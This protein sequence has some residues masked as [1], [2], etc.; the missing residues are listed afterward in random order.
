M[1]LDYFVLVMLVF[2]IV[3]IFYGVIVIY[4]I[5]Y[6]IVKKCNYFY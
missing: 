4:D 3:V 6:E 2:V 5:F 1:F